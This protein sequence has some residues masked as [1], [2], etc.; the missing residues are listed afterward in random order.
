M[1]LPNSGWEDNFTFLYYV[2]DDMSL[3]VKR[4]PSLPT[5]I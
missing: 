3:F 1:S 4:V 5:K 2:C